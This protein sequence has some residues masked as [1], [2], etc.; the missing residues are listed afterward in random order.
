M[1]GVEFNDVEVQQRRGG[2]FFLKGLEEME[3]RS[4]KTL[5]DSIHRKLISDSILEGVE[6]VVNLY[7]W[8]ACD[9]IGLVCEARCLSS[10]SD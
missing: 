6:N 8:S 5:D 7:N 4:A 10:G 2:G 3:R 1:T 9:T